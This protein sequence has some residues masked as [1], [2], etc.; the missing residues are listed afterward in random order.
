MAVSV[1]TEKILLQ[2]SNAKSFGKGDRINN[3]EPI[4]LEW[5]SVEALIV[6]GEEPELHDVEPKRE[7]GSTT[8]NRTT[9]L[10]K[11]FSP[12]KVINRRETY[13]F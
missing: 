3:F 12:P 6:P 4:E 9:A 2:D 1:K 13:T 11:E 7:K 10:A 8:E 5:K